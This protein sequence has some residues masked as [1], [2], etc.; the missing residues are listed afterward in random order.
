MRLKS[1]HE[2]CIPLAL[3]VISSGCIAGRLPLDRRFEPD[4]AVEW[5]FD[6][7]DELYLALGFYPMIGP[8]EIVAGACHDG[9]VILGCAVCSDV[10]T[11]GSHAYVLDVESGRVLKS[12]PG[13]RS[14]GWTDWMITPERLYFC[15]FARWGAFDLESGRVHRNVPEPDLSQVIRRYPEGSSHEEVLGSPARGI[16][17]VRCELGRGRIMNFTQDG[18]P[19][20]WHTLDL[21]WGTDTD[22]PR[23]TRLCRLPV[24]AGVPTACSV[25]ANDERRLLFVC[26]NYLVCVDVRRLSGTAGL[27]AS[28]A[29]VNG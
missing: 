12:I 5:I 1:A 10:A 6:A 7:G 17:V 20:G 24:R 27:P 9:K 16:L 25:L 3:A 14:M 2:A 4:P 19:F 22:R 8:P 13:P 23:Q 18:R 11:V 28:S 21:I 26:G 29:P 15:S